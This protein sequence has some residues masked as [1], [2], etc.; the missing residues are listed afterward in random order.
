VRAGLTAVV[1]AGLGCA[2]APRP[3]PFALRLSPAALGHPLF[4]S[5]RVTV[6]GPGTERLGFEALLEVEPGMLRLAA[7]AMGQTMVRMSFDGTAL[8]EQL[9]PRLPK[10][11]SGAQILTAIQLAWWPLDAI[12]AALPRGFALEEA[13]GGRRLLEDGALLTAITYDG[14]PP[15]WRRVR[16]SSPRAGYSLEIESVEAPQ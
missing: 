13:A 1:L 6:V 16:V 9:S 14:A 7:V 2:T 12:R 5:Q 15:A 11:V 8:V 10:A 4:L 3:A